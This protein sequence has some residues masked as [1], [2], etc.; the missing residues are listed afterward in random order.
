[1]GISGFPTVVARHGEQG[2]LLA[3]C[4]ATAAG[5]DAALVRAVDVLGPSAAGTERVIGTPTD[6]G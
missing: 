1:M 2:Y 3:R 5:L 6:H 4:Y